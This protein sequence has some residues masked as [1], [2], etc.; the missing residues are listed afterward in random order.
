MNQ[1]YFAASFKI[2]PS[3]L[4]RQSQHKPGGDSSP[5]SSPS[6][7]NNRSML[8]K[9][10]TDFDDSFTTHEANEY[11]LNYF[12]QIELFKFCSYLR[13]LSEPQRKVH[14]NEEL[15]AQTMSELYI[16]HPRPKVAR[17]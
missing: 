4:S 12:F 3:V 11:V 14:L 16:S 10:K 7:T 8:S 17:R 9:R 6:S 13:R 2:N 15:V 5:R 1:L